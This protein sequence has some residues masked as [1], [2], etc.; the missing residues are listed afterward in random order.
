MSR[1]ADAVPGATRPG[2]GGSHPSL[3]P[4][5]E[6]SPSPGVQP[7]AGVPQRPSP[8]VA[9]SGIVGDSILVNA[10]VARTRERR[11]IARVRRLVAVSADP[12]L[13]RHPA[14]QWTQHLS[15]R[16]P[17][18]LV[19]RRSPRRP[20]RSHARCRD[21]A[22]AARRRPVAP[23]ADP[24]RRDGGRTG[25]PR[26]D[27]WDQGRGRALDQPFPRAP[28]LPRHD[29]WYGPS[30]HPLRGPTG[31]RQ[32]LR[33]Q[34]DG[35]GGQR[36]IPLRLSLGASSRCIYGQTNRKIRSFFKQLRKHARKEGGAIGFIEEIDA[37]GAQPT[38]HGRQ[39]RDRRRERRGQRAL[40]PAA[41]VRSARPR[42]QRMASAG[43]TSSTVTCPRGPSSPS[44]PSC[45][46][47]CWWSG[48][49]P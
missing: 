33:G 23:Q 32:D 10:D 25:G 9:M 36:A 30:G 45:P 13:G 35:Q 5:L 31:D 19:G 28:D 27:R 1:S 34:G 38:R 48:H 14:S 11:R 24:A 41:I 49:Q 43:S 42:G 18:A 40:G 37:I 22:S 12:R 29:G 2:S 44:R 21:G 8:R 7:G 16:A 46:P 20:D 4:R 26:R 3:A 39:R 6:V 15:R 17:P 47:T